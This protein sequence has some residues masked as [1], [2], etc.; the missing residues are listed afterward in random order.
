MRYEC[1]TCGKDY[2]SKN[3]L[4]NLH[5]NEN[6]SHA[7]DDWDECPGCGK[8][9][10][11]VGSHWSHNESC[12]PDYTI[13]QEN[14][15][16]G[17]LMGDATLRQRTKY[18]PRL[19][20][21]SITRE[22]LKFL[23]DTFGILSTDVR[24]KADSDY[25]ARKAR[26]NGLDRNATGDSYSDIYSLQLRSNRYLKKYTHWYE[27]G[28]K[29][30]PEDISLEPRTL[31]HWFVNDGSLIK[32]SYRPHLVIVTSNEIENKDKLHKMF[33]NIGVEIPNFTKKSI[34]FGVDES[35]TLWEYMGE[36]LPGFKY[37][38]PKKYHP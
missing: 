13:E 34:V 25:S 20:I 19:V 27:S 35:E 7:P 18:N 33:N 31:K 8:R 14:I 6:P 23:S 38:W 28:E 17:L 36:P 16:K 11:Y 21:P 5:Y 3:S 22:Y 24:L 10:H 37:K 2:S 12:V 32:D 15:I 1:V 30:F 29:V 4:R 9:Y 26:E